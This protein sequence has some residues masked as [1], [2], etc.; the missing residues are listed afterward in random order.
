MPTGEASVP[1]EQEVDALAEQAVVGGRSGCR[2][3]E[4]LVVGRDARRLAGGSATSP[5]AGL[6]LVLDSGSGANRSSDVADGAAHLVGASS[7]RRSSRVGRPHG[8][9]EGLGLAH[10]ARVQAGG[11]A[12]V[13]VAAADPDLEPRHR[14]PPMRIVRS[15]PATAARAQASGSVAIS[16]HGAIG[17]R[18]LGA[19]RVHRARA[20][21]VAGVGARSPS[22][23]RA[24]HAAA[25]A[26]DARRASARRCAGPLA[27][28]VAQRRRQRA[29]ARLQRAQALALRVAVDVPA[30]RRPRDRPCR[31]WARD[32]AERNVVMRC[33]VGRRV[34]E[35]VA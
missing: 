31:S 27:V 12:Q 3:E 23:S 25:A 4:R 11:V 24:E 7:A 8:R 30:R 16:E 6:G 9:E 15:S 29:V 28:C 10:R 19:R 13:V 35:A 22:G 14:C 18:V 33:G 1:V 20:D 17:R 32:A 5:L 21:D 34:L 26:A 2:R